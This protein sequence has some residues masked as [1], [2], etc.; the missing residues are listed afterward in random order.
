M[1]FE[2][3]LGNKE[4]KGS[5]P[6]RFV[7]PDESENNQQ[8]FD[9]P[10]DDQFVHQRDPMFEHKI[11]Q[12]ELEEQSKSAH[13]QRLEGASRISPAAKKRIEILSGIGRSTKDVEIDGA[14][15]SLR[16]LKGMEIRQIIKEMFEIQGNSEQMYYLRAQ[17]LAY[18]L[19][20]VDGQDFGL[21]IGS[22]LIED[23]VKFVQEL[24][25]YVLQKLNDEYA[26]LASS[27]KKKYATPQ[28]EVKE[29]VED[30]KKSS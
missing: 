22:D 14:I 7:V 3:S 18:S 30:L 12:A 24:D 25:E 5:P 13:R 15:F 28:D 19:Y 2:S 1:K 23:K 17:T 6:R 26:A 27:A 9:V 20:S 29:V 10:D 11:T 16:T 21:I 4:I 8:Q